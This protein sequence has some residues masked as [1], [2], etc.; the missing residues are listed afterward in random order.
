MKNPHFSQLIYAQAKKYGK[1]P[2]LYYRENISDEWSHISWAG[3]GHQVSSL[4]KSFIESG[5]GEQQRVAQF[6]QNKYENLIVDFALYSIRGVLVPIYATSSIQP[7][8]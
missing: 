7:G 5:V 8:E 1:K 3:F 6:S 4:A 2:A